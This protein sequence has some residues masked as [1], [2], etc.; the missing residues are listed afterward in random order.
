[1]SVIWTNVVLPR[2]SIYLQTNKKTK[3]SNWICIVYTWIKSS[4]TRIFFF[5]VQRFHERN[6]IFL[7]LS[8]SIYIQLLIRPPHAT[9]Q[10]HNNISCL[11]IASASEDWFSWYFLVT[12]EASL[13][14]GNCGKLNLWNIFFVLRKSGVWYYY[15]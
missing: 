9:V 14:V 3:L 8:L 10:V 15:W 12:R 7:I 1:M 2:R 11:L 4:S 13:W 5:K 6:E